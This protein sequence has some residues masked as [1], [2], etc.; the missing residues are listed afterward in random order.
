MKKIEKI[1]LHDINND[2][3]LF[4]LLINDKSL[5]LKMDKIV[6]ICLKEQIDTYLYIKNMNIDLEKT[7]KA[8]Y[9]SLE[10]FKKTGSFLEEGVNY[11]LE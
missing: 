8:L 11:E 7:N 9:E 4:D 3:M 2:G 10:R 6:L 5:K 1:E